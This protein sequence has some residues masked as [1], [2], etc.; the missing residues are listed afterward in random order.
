ML[1]RAKVSG[2]IDYRL[3]EIE[4]YVDLG[5][6]SYRRSKK[7]N[8]KEVFNNEETETIL[9]YL[10]NNIDKHNLGILLMFVKG[11]RVGEVATLKNENIV[12]N[13][14]IVENSETRYK[15]SDGIVYEVGFTKTTR[16]ERSVV[17]PEGC[18]WICS[19][20]RELN[21]NG[22]FVFVNSKGRMTTNCFRGRLRTI[23]KNLGFIQKSPHK[24]RKTYSS[25]IKDAGVGDIL[26]KS[27]MGH[28]NIKTTEENYY[29]DRIKKDKKSQVLGN[30]KDFDIVKKRCI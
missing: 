5:K 23:C 3:S 27:Q 28:T 8:E 9:S 20:L 13:Y 22:E 19:L 12:D 14:I 17:L 2:F 21:P 29:R 10:V 6:N 18:E 24:I 16:S 26:I 4:E 30:V 1:K 7:D 15:T 25:I 11:L